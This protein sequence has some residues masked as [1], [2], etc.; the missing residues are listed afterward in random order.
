MRGVVANEGVSSDIKFTSEVTHDAFMLKPD[1]LRRRDVIAMDR[2]NI[3]HSMFEAMT[4]VGIVYVTK[5]KMNL[6]YT[7]VSDVIL[8]VRIISAA[9]AHRQSREVW[10]VTNY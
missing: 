3:D 5:M 2:T 9:E 4:S 10:I 6:R 1:A 7:I 8:H